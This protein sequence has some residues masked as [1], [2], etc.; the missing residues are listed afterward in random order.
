MD[1]GAEKRHVKNFLRCQSGTLGCVGK[2]QCIEGCY[3][4]RSL[5]GGPLLLPDTT[6]G[7]YP[8]EPVGRQ[9]YSVRVP[10]QE[11]ADSQPHRERQILAICRCLNLR[12]NDLA[13]I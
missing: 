7:S 6:H 4:V 2:T 13:D 8:L 3:G 12:I 5:V 1:N 9:S 11:L 10:A